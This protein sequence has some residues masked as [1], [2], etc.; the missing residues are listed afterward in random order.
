MAGGKSIRKGAPTVLLSTALLSVWFASSVCSTLVNKDLMDRFPYAVTLSAVHMLSSVVVD[1]AIIWYRGLHTQ[2]RRDVFINCLPVAATINAG[3][4]MT[5]V[6]YGLVPASLTHTAKA[7]SPVFSVLVSKVLFNQV[8]TVMT[9][10]SLIPITVGVTLSALTEINW[11]FLG[12]LAAVAAALAN[13]LNSTYT[14]KALHQAGAPDPLIF[15]MYTA[16]AAVVMLLPYALLVEM[17]TISLW[18]PLDPLAGHQSLSLQTD[19]AVPVTA[20]TTLHSIP[21]LP[22]GPAA[23]TIH[24][25]PWSSMLLSLLLHY[26]QN[27]SNIYFLNGV[28]VLTHQVAQSL[29]RL[30]N[31]AGAVL[32]F[33]NAVTKMNVIGM[34]LAL[35]GFSMYSAAKQLH[36]PVRPRS[37]ST[38]FLTHSRTTSPGTHHQALPPAGGQLSNGASPNNLT[39]VHVHQVAVQSDA[40]DGARSTMLNGAGHTGLLPKYSSIELQPTWPSSTNYASTSSSRMQPPSSQHR[41]PLSL[42]HR[43]LP[44]LTHTR[45]ATGDSESSLQSEDE[46]STQPSPEGSRLASLS[47]HHTAHA[48]AMLHAQALAAGQGQHMSVVTSQGGGPLHHSSSKDAMSPRDDN[49]CV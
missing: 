33:G 25:F 28:S 4:L 39:S 11:V 44:V 47:L 20:S 9:F 31:I 49:F 29:K 46:S 42:D 37:A 34:G 15:H 5:Y 14:K 6:S 19:L 38:A 2:F 8:P 40:F 27:I 45:G 24:V 10:L 17:P 3:K 13:V 1:F 23:V 21:V 48:Q 18:Q 35:L 12:F 43:G 41:F 36:G 16:C 7:S 30:L 32:Y 26:A 22:K